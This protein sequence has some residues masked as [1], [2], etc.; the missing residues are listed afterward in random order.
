VC[1]QDAADLGAA[2]GDR[3]VADLARGSGDRDALAGLDLGGA[4]GW[5]D[6]H[7][8]RGRGGPGACLA[9]AGPLRG[10]CRAGAGGSE[11]GHDPD[12]RHEAKPDP[13]AGGQVT[14]ACPGEVALQHSSSCCAD[15][16][17]GGG[18][19]QYSPS[20]KA[21][22]PVYGEGAVPSPGTAGSD[23]EAL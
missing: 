20:P 5:R 14:L 1:R 17:A 15:S 18:W 2:R 23:P 19:S 11:Q 13:P 21:Y 10:G 7:P 4:V 16:T 8:G 3:D 9:M 22:G 6:G 12:D